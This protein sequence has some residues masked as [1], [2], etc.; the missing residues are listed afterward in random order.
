MVEIRS[1]ESIDVHGAKIA[2][3]EV[4]RQMPDG[5]WIGFPVHEGMN[6]ASEDTGAICPDKPVVRVTVSLPQ[7]VVD[8]VVQMAEDRQERIRRSGLSPF[9]YL[10]TEVFKQ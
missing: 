6:T 8:A 4:L 1:G 3:K 10:C 2:R 5:V 9:G 7:E